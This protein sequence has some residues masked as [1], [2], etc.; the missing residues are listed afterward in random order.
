MT[1]K[2]S[3]MWSQSIF[4]ALSLS[5]SF[6]GHLSPMNLLCCPHS[7]DIYASQQLTRPSSSF[8]TIILSISQ[9]PGLKV[10]SLINQSISISQCLSLSHSGLKVF[11]LNQWIAL[12]LSLSFFSFPCLFFFL[13]TFLFPS[14]LLHDALQVLQI[15]FFSPS[16][17]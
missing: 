6:Y 11:S 9:G 1:L 14:H 2:P 3:F 16:E 13:G 4:S 15:L 5:T 17:G 10:F 7:K 12:S 8:S